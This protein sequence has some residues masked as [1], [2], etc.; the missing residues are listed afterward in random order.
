VSEAKS[1]RKELQAGAFYDPGAQG[2]GRG[3]RSLVA[4]GSGFDGTTAGPPSGGT[5]KRAVQASAFGSADAPVSAAKT[6]ARA[7][8][9][10]GFGQTVDTAAPAKAVERVQVEPP[11]IL[12]KPLPRYTAEARAARI[13]G[14]VVIKV[15]LKSNGDVQIIEI[16]KGLGHGLD[17]AAHKAA[18]Q[19][20]F[21][22]AHKGGVAVDFTT[23]LRIVFQLG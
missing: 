17:E 10:A 3:G 7:M 8:Q 9:D 12:S 16:V 22:P 5:G 6:Q 23:T 21:R 14:D 2:N 15:N 1:A 20:R 11:E 4:T 13:E 19:I 18:E